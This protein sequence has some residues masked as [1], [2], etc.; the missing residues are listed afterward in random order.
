[1]NNNLMHSYKKYRRHQIDTY[2]LD[3][4]CVRNANGD[5]VSKRQ[6]AGGGAAYGF[7]AIAAFDSARSMMHFRK[8]LAADLA[9]S[10]KRSKAAK[11]G[12]KTRRA[13]G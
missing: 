8:T 9:A 13:A 1:M 11:K 2:Q 12:W 5:L 3:G 10:A 7:H 4:L 6:F